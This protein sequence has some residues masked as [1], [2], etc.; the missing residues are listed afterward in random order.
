MK[1]GNLWPLAHWPKITQ[2]CC[3]DSRLSQQL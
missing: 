2:S 3:F 1:G